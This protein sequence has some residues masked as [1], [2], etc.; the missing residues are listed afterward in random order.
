MKNEDKLKPHDVLWGYF[1]RDNFAHYYY[2]SETKY[3]KIFSAF[4]VN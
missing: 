4:L 3:V 2:I 1:A